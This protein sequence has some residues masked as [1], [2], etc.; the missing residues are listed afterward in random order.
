MDLIVNCSCEFCILI[1]E[2]NISIYSYFG[3]ILKQI[4]LNINGKENEAA[5]VPSKHKNID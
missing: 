2:L 4:L 3:G 1:M 5:A